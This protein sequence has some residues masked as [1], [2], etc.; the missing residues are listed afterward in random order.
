MSQETRMRAPIDNK[1]EAPYDAAAENIPA[2]KYQEGQIIS[3][4]D[5][6]DITHTYRIDEVLAD[7]DGNIEYLVSEEIYPGEWH[8]LGKDA[9]SENA[10]PFNVPEQ[11]I[12]NQAE[13]AVIKEVGE[14][15][16]IID[17]AGNELITATGKLRAAKAELAG[18]SSKSFLAKIFHDLKGTEAKLRQQISDLEEEIKEWEKITETRADAEKV[19]M[20]IDFFAEKAAEQPRIRELKKTG[21]AKFAWAAAALLLICS[22]GPDKASSSGF[23]NGAQAASVETAHEVVP[24]EEQV[25]LVYTAEFDKP[26]EVKG[27]INREMAKT[28]PGV[29]AEET[30]NNFS[31][32]EASILHV[33]QEDPQIA[34]KIAN[35]CGPNRHSAGQFYPMDPEHFLLA[36]KYLEKANYGAPLGD[37]GQYSPDQVMSALWSASLHH[38]TP[39]IAD[40]DFSKALTALS[41]FQNTKKSLQ[42]ARGF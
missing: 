10:L 17:N 26:L 31:A 30:E 28:T 27:E 13:Q 38:G 9:I 20:A 22:P 23:S 19:I 36:A 39:R 11:P 37:N 1:K 29:K 35:R 42:Q 41:G 21:A 8:P 14:A 40:E 12:A 3:Y 5:N 24:V 33:M 32:A 15:E 4:T 18:L 16:E 7:K 6:L 34:E 25:P 2:G